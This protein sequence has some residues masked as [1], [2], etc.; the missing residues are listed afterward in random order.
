MKTAIIAICLLLAG[1][2]FT[3][4]TENVSIT[5]MVQPH[6]I[7]FILG[8]SFAIALIQSG[9]DQLKRAFA[10]IKQSS[11]VCDVSELAKKW[12]EI[13]RFAQ[14]SSLIKVDQF[15]NSINHELSS[16]ALKLIADNLKTEE[17]KQALGAKA[18]KRHDDLVK[19]ANIWQDMAD[20]APVIGIMGTVLTL[21]TIFSSTEVSQIMAGLVMA[22]SATLYGLISS[23]MVFGPIGHRIRHYAETQLQ[24]DTLIVNAATLIADRKN[25]SA[26]VINFEGA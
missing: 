1:F 15:A 19:L 26:M 2:G 14:K 22:F 9:F 13:S 10:A 3:I 21:A 6:M 18:Q 7:L 5:R 16:E 12:Q 8:I 23:S 20:K 11:K 25:V 4:F 24:I 17:L